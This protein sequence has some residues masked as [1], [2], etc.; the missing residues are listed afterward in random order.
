PVCVPAGAGTGKT[1]AITH[2]IAYGA[3]T[4][5]L[6][7]RPVLAVTF[8]AKAAAAMR[9]RLRDLRVP[10][11]HARTS[12]SAALRPLRPL[13]PRVV[14]GALRDFVAEVEWSR[15]SMLTPESYPDAVEKSRRPGVAGFDPRS[16]ARILTQYEEV[17]KDRGVIDFEDVL[18]HMVGFLTERP[19][20][21][22]E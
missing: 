21:A 10:A 3:A 15:V 1:R 22:R 2:R 17:K 19:D 5:R 16:I 20:V 18:L 4:G 13:S 9:P 11:A 7:P 12:P 6:N 8:T 14:R